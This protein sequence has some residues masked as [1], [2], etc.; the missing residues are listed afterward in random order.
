[1][2]RLVLILSVLSSMVSRAQDYRVSRPPN[3]IAEDRI[4]YIS[5]VTK[6]EMELGELPKHPKIT[7]LGYSSIRLNND[8]YG[9]MQTDNRISFIA[10]SPG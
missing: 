3:V 6:A 1:M 2:F 8:P 9:N 5:I 7:W 4:E 10:T